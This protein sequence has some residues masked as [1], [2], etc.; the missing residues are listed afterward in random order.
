[1]ILLAALIW[2]PTWAI[3]T[4]GLL[5]IVFQRIFSL[6]PR[7]LPEAL[8]NS[9]GWIWEFVYPAGLD[10]SSGITILYVLA[11]WIGVMA[12]GY[13]FGAIMVREP[14]GWRRI[15]LT[16]GLAATALFLV[17]GVVTV[18]RH[19]APPGAPPVLVRLL[20][21]QKYPPSQ[22]FLLMTLGPTIA[23]LPLAERAR[24]WFGGV[25][26]TFGSVPLFYYLL[27]IP[28]IHLAALVVWF[29]R[30]GTFHSEYFATAPFVSV[31]VEHRWGLPL[32]YLVFFIVVVLLYFPCRWFA[33]VKARKPKGWLRYL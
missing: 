26:K 25:L 18:L 33:S 20:N 2:L 27:H 30:E 13:A 9:V 29:L 6:L 8:R 15:C 14:A 19:P 22:L 7:A 24:G 1:M 16:I 31:P 23:L 17:V 5:I 21:Q 32:L 4:V 11:P 28:V 10:N 3:G 12:I